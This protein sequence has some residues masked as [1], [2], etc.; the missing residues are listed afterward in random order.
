MAS[1]TKRGLGEAMIDTLF[2]AKGIALLLLPPALPLVLILWGLLRK[3]RTPAFL[4]LALLWLLSTP[5]VAGWLQWSLEGDYF[6]PQT[7]SE[8]P[9]QRYAV[10]LGGSVS[11]PRADLDSV[12]FHDST[13]RL[14]IGA[15]LIKKDIANTL[16]FS[17]GTADRR[18]QGAVEA[19]VAGLLLEEWGIASERILLEGRSRSTWQNA[20]ET[21]RLLGADSG[22][23]LLVTSASHMRRAI[24]T[25]EHVGFDV[26][27]VTAD[28]SSAQRP[29]ST[30]SVFSL[31]PDAGS[32][33]ASRNALWEWLGIVWYRVK[34]V[35]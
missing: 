17:G 11:A 6:P 35:R 12:Q 1:A 33:K 4:G 10:V 15:R 13:D 28:F 29:D 27:P 20:I 9:Q 5:W 22:P 7:L 2:I 18:S 23:I 14:W 32:L 26:I 24:W 25:F 8:L 19:D 16:V 34:G 3:N 31:L 30:P 21:R